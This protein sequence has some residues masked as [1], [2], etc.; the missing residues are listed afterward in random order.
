MF[1]VFSLLVYLL[2]MEDHQIW[3][4]TP[5]FKTFVLKNYIE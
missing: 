2:Q 3:E 4:L 5:A 1:A